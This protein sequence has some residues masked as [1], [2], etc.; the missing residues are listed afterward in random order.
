MDSRLTWVLAGLGGL[1]LVVLLTFAVASN[2][3]SGEQ[4]PGD[5]EVT[6]AEG[7]QPD[8]QPPPSEVTPAEGESGPTGEG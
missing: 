2:E 6:P 7:E 8:E 3:T 5:S 4:P 1:F